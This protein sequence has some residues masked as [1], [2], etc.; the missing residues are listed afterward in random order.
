[1]PKLR[2]GR[3]TSTR[4]YLAGLVLALSL[5]G[6]PS[7]GAQAAGDNESFLVALLLKT[8]AMKERRALDIQESDRALETSERALKRPRRE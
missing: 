1:M 3:S 8:A 2:T 6:I 5:F 7:P 4:F